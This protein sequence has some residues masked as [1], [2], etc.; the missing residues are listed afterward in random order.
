MLRLW[1]ILQLE[2]LEDKQEEDFDMIEKLKTY[3]GKGPK[4]S[5]HCQTVLNAIASQVVTAEG[6]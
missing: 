2:S 4:G 6:G 1:Q 5:A 3:L